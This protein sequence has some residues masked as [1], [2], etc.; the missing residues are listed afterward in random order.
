MQKK[1]P[2]GA[3][4]RNV[5]GKTNLSSLL[6]KNEQTKRPSQIQDQKHQ[7]ADFVQIVG[8][9]PAPSFTLDCPSDTESSS[10]LTDDEKEKTPATV[11]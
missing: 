1:T 11:D 7:K 9:P 5:P 8:R 3:I 6:T 2:A 4:K 10:D